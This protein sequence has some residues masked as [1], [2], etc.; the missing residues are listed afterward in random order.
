VVRHP[1][2]AQ[3]DVHDFAF[4]HSI[5]QPPPAHVVLQVAL[6]SQRKVQPPP[7]QSKVHVVPPLQVKAHPSP[8]QPSVHADGAV[9]EQG[10]FFVHSVGSSSEQAAEA[11]A[12]SV[13]SATNVSDAS[14]RVRI[15]LVPLWFLL[16]AAAA[17]TIDDPD[18]DA[19]EIEVLAQLVH[20]EALIRE[21]D[22][23]G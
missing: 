13:R 1:L 10:E 19:F 22:R 21:M 8:T 20:D 12:T 3:S 4:A 9:H 5:T 16:L 2:P 11:D 14:V 7:G 17:L 15:T 6:S 18:R 23:L